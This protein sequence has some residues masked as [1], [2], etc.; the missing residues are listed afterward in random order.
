MLWFGFWLGVKYSWGTPTPHS[1]PDP[2][3]RA[4]GP[5]QNTRPF[6][7]WGGVTRS[8]LGPETRRDQVTPN[9]HLEDL[10]LCFF[11]NSFR[12]HMLFCFGIKWKFFLR[13]GVRKKIA[14]LREV[15]DFW[16]LAAPR[17]NKWRLTPIISC[18]R[19]VKFHGYSKLQAPAPQRRFIHFNLRS[20][21][22]TVD[23]RGKQ[24]ALRDKFKIHDI[25][26][27]LFFYI[28]CIGLQHSDLFPPSVPY[29][30]G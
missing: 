25:G 3:S 2:R 19:W 17:T 18:P 29:T 13:F 21:Y 15:C 7:L 26:T 14:R 16:P 27:T 12:G 11:R 8:R 5:P 4:S 24:E 6:I 23:W 28:A 9:C 1:P 22:T 20:R 30:Q 10:L